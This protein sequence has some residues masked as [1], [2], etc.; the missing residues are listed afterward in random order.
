MTSSKT[1]RYKLLFLL[2]ALIVGCLICLSPFFVL[3]RFF[4]GVDVLSSNFCTEK[5]VVYQTFLLQA[6]EWDKRFESI[7]DASF[8]F[9]FPDGQ[10][11]TVFAEDRFS[12][13]KQIVVVSLWA[14]RFRFGKAGYIYAPTGVPP[15]G[16]TDDK[17]T[18][19][20]GDFYCYYLADPG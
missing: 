10:N 7:Q 4:T 9:Y 5:D 1:S 14:P 6:K 19:M 12:N 17:I 15:Y 3:Y 11:H 2:L 18:H 8:E 16:S 20:D 13:T